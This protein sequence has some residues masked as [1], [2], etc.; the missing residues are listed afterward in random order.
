M[1]FVHGAFQGDTSVLG[2]SVRADVIAC[3]KTS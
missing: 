1:L 3:L 2:V